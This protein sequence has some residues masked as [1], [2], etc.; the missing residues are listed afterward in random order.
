M[1]VGMVVVVMIM[2]M[3]QGTSQ[4][5]RQM[6]MW[7][8]LLAETSTG[9]KTSEKS[10]PRPSGSYSFP[11]GYMLRAGEVVPMVE[12]AVGCLLSVITSAR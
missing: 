2:R 5:T 6:A 4:S 11:T 1:S 12:R 9:E 8:R 10:I 7:R 3:A